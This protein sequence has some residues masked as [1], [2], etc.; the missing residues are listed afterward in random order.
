MMMIIIIVIIIIIII[1]IMITKIVIIGYS[2]LKL[3]ERSKQF[4]SCKIG[5]ISL[6]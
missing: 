2:E 1:V 4:Y 5:L 6:R 3:T